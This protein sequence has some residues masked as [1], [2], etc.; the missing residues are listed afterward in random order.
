MAFKFYKQLNAMD[1]GPTCLRMIANSYGKHYSAESLRRLSG[2]SKNGVSMWGLSDSAQKIGMRT[3]AGRLTYR[4]LEEAP[5]PAVLHWNQN[6]FVVLVSMD[7]KKCKVADPSTGIITFRKDEFLRYWLSSKDDND[8]DTGLVLL[9]E[10][11]P[12]FYEQDAEKG[13]KLNWEIA[14]QYLRHSN[15]QLPQIFLALVINF[16]IGLIF[17]FLTKSVVDIG[18]NTKN[19]SYITVV[20]F[21]QLMLVLSGTIVGFISGRLQLRL[22]NMLNISILSDF[23]IKLTSLPLSYFDNHRTGDTLQRLGDNRLIQSYITNIALNTIFSVIN[24]LVYSV[25]LLI[26]SPQLFFI[27]LIGNLIYM[28]WIRIF[29]GIRRKLNYETFHLSARENNAT[30]QLVQGMQ[31]IRLNNAEQQKRWEWEN[32]QAKIFKLSFRAMAFNQWQSLGGLLI[33][34]G[35]DILLSFVVARY[36]VEGQLTFGAML[37][38]QYIIGQLHG[39]VGDFIGL[40]QSTQDAKISLERLNEVHE[41]DDEEPAR[42]NFTRELPVRKDIELKNLRFSYPGSRTP[43]L[44]DINLHIPEGKVTAIVGVSGS[45]KTTL[46]KILMKVYTDYEG[47]IRVGPSNFK[48]ISHSFWRRNSGAVMQDGYIF[49]DSIANNISVGNEEVD[50]ERLLTCLEIANITAFIQDLPNGINT[51]L[52]TDGVGVSQGQKQRLLIARAIYKDPAF[53]FFDEATNALDANNEKAIVENL[54]KF[55]LNRTVL[56]VAHRLSTVRNADKIVVLKNGRIVEEGNHHELTT[57]RGHYFELVK[58]Q[59]ELGD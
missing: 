49:N 47:E 8:E 45:G 44:D 2:Y 11:S 22:S 20:L 17:P 25:I 15:G 33:T 27:F 32:I 50:L 34:Q 51:Q 12:A 39:P 59:L 4:V 38:V 53:M 23:W 5:L 55:F 18:I 54:A 46:L 24:F 28:G 56:I 31:E 41:M 9:M 58:N 29:L 3:R 43:V 1:C 42:E 40:I 30:L 19:L 26:F 10:P 36:V 37:A 13:R 57:L 48:H 7:D 6:H 35:K 52:G 16:G 21:A 14:F